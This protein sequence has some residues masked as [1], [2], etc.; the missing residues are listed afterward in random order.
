MEAPMK[1]MILI[2]GNPTSRKLWE[3]FSDAQRAE[4]FGVYAALREELAASGELIVAEAL[5]DPS[6]GR[7]LPATDDLAM[8]TD[9]PF[10]EVKEQLAGFFLV[11]CESL[12]RAIQHAARIPEAVY[13]LVEVRPVMDLSGMDM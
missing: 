10:A 3:G 2:H 12:E 7:R 1:Y 13:G 11:D 5:A 8:R 6:M 4:G 9:G